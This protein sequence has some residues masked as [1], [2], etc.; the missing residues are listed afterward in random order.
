MRAHQTLTRYKGPVP[1]GGFVLGNATDP[2]DPNASATNPG[3]PGTQASVLGCRN[4]TVS[5]QSI[6]RMGVCYKGPAAAIPLSAQLWFY[7]QRSERWYA[8]EAAKNITPDRITW[9]DVPAILEMTSSVE[10]NST[11]VQ[12]YLAVADGA[13]PNGQYDFGFIPSI[14]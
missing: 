13:T 1:A 11:S 4:Q 7:E 2:T 3:P 14:S 12:S 8:I 5:G 10:N 6:K 9:F